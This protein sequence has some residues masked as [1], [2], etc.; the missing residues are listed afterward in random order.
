MAILRES[1]PVD[2]Q[3]HTLHLTGPIVHVATRAEDHVE[4]WFD[5]RRGIP[6][7]RNFRV[8]GTGQTVTPAACRHIGSAVT[9]T[10]QVVWHLLEL[11][12]GASR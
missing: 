9:P 5:S 11:T 7:Q 3:W 10:S 8:F 12:P 6:Q 1:V 2:D 4:L